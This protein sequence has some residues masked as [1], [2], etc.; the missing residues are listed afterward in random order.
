MD[1]M[2]LL[3]LPSG[4]DKVHTA[5]SHG[6]RSLSFAIIADIERKNKG[7][8]YRLAYR[9]SWSVSTLICPGADG[10]PSVP[11]DIQEA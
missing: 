2:C 8:I 4:P 7:N 9:R 1:N 3:L 10:A 5:P 6:T 11:K